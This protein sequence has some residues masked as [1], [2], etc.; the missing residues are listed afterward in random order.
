MMLEDTYGHTSHRK[1]LQQ[2]DVYGIAP[3]QELKSRSPIRLGIICAGGVAQSKYFP[4]IA[5]LRTTWEQV[6]VTA[7]AESSEA[8]GRKVE[9]IWG[10][11]WHPSYESMLA[12]EDI[13]GLL[14]LGPDH[15]HAE[16]T[17]AGLERNLPVLVEKPISRSL[18]QAERMCQVAEERHVPL[19]TVAM[20]RYSPPY[21]RAKQII[22]SGVVPDPALYVAK[23]NLGYD[24]VDLLESGTIHIFDL[25]RFFMGDVNKLDALAV[26]KHRRSKYPFDNA[27]ITLEFR[28]NSIGTIYTS[29]SALSF[30]PWERVEIYGDH[31]WLAI[32][33]QSELLLYDSE[34]GPIKSW[35]PVMTNTLLFDEEF[36]GYM[37]QVENFLQVIRKKEEPLVTGRDG[38]RALELAAATHLSLARRSPVELPLNGVDADE[39]LRVWL[40]DPVATAT[41]EK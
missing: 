19:M 7:F 15:L 13:D 23:F 35:K 28:D 16:H 31:A 22:S 36:L 1:A 20:K 26:N 18:A 3:D 2:S 10:A 9:S 4:A 24:Y 8:Q 38:L 29:C 41:G 6:E 34:T 27:V 37:G 40:N 33:D 5:R 21:R 11:R 25:T 32:E 39:E 30:K 14:V 12:E 17:I